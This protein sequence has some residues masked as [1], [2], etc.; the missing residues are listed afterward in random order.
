MISQQTKYGNQSFHTHNKQHYIQNISNNIST[1]SSD[2]VN[3][4]K[5]FLHSHSV[6]V[7]I[8]STTNNSNSSNII[9]SNNTN[10]N[11]NH[12]NINSSTTIT[13]TI[14]TIENDFSIIEILEDSYISCQ[15]A[16]EILNDILSYDK[17][18]ANDMKLN[19]TI[20]DVKSI[21]ER[22]ISPFVVQVNNFFLILFLFYL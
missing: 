7:N 14:N 9:S 10:T 3:S 5:L 4:Q 16:V 15:T 2:C 12:N 13:S 11:I 19:T 20:I 22:C 21:L 18:E 1:S 6:P 17:L 8:S